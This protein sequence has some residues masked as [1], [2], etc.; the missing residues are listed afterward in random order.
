M[1]TAEPYFPEHRYRA[2]VAA[3]IARSSRPRPAVVVGLA[4]IVLVCIVALVGPLLAPYSPTLPAGKPYTAPS[5]TFLFGTDEVGR[6]IFSRVLYGVQTTW[7]SA[8]IVIAMSVVIG[9]AIG[10]VAGTLGGLVDSALMRFTDLFLAMPATI[11]AIAVVAALGPSLVNTLIAITI[12]WWPLYARIVRGEVRAYA[13]RP[14]LAAA[15]LAGVGTVRIARRHL[16]PGAVPAVLIT[17][18][19]DVGVL[20]L[21]LA[22]LSYL[23]L[24]QLEPAPE[25]GKMVAAGI[26]YVLTNWWIAIIPGLA[27]FV[28]AVIANFGGDALRDLIKTR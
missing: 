5:A 6:D 18:S 1:A 12:V 9:G 4:G 14:H 24:G 23:G 2:R 25:L 16:L 17:A 21:T 7:W 22:L 27:V 3:R 26:P 11:L 28:L 19:L 8:L 15:R 10:L 20:I 13:A